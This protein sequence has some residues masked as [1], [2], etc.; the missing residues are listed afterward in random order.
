MNRLTTVV[1][2][3]SAAAI[4]VACNLESILEPPDHSSGGQEVDRLTYEAAWV[5]YYQGTGSADLLDTGDSYADLPVCLETWVEAGRLRG[6]VYVRLGAPPPDPLLEMTDHNF[7]RDQDAACAGL[8]VTMTASC[9]TEEVISK[10]QL[11]LSGVHYLSE[12][13]S[14]L[15]LS[16]RIERQVDELV[17]LLEIERGHSQARLHSQNSTVARFSLQVNKVN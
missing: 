13:G 5:G 1:S 2:L 14:R 10:D 16:L 15:E 7:S 11:L 12:N 9:S 6:T 4:A 8:G 17:G 3:V